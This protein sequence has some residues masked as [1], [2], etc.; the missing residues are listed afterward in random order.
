[1]A[2]SSV[3]SLDTLLHQIEAA[4]PVPWYPKLHAETTG[5]PRD[6]LDLPLEKLRMAGLIRLTEWMEGRGQGY[7]LTPEGMH[8][9][10]SERE[11]ARL[12][13]GI[14]P[15]RP[16]PERKST[17]GPRW[18]AWDRGE[19][20]RE[21]LLDPPN[22]VVAKSLVLI[23]IMVFLAGMYLA[24]QANVPANIYLF[25]SA[26]DQL[27]ARALGEAKHNI[28]AL[29]PE[30]LI[31]G[32]WWRLLTYCFVHHGLIHI[33]LNM[34]ALY[35]ISKYLEPMWGHVR[36]LVVYLIAGVGGGCVA[37][38]VKPNAFLAGASGA[39]CGLIAAEAVWIVL[40]RAHLPG[41]LF[42]AWMRNIGIN[43]ILI[44]IIST[45]PN[46]S[47]S[48][49]FGGAAIGAV[50]A[51]LLH[52]QRYGFGVARWLALVAVP[53]VPVAS[54]G[55]LI[56]TMNTKPLWVQFREK[57]Q[58]E[59]ARE[60]DRALIERY[61]R[62]AWEADQKARE[63]YNRSYELVAM[64]PERRD[65]EAKQSAIEALTRARSG[66]AEAINR[67]SACPPART[68]TLEEARLGT[69][70]YLQALADLCDLSLT[71]LR[72]DRNLL[73]ANLNA[74]EEQAAKVKDLQKR[75]ARY[76]Q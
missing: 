8:A 37:M 56:Y 30:D 32:Q 12:R 72:E 36:F 19:Q 9:L 13:D 64:H 31:R 76:I 40:N 65:P 68:A 73:G 67:V 22:A 21:V 34:A 71:D 61:R 45:L 70:E 53:L 11:L 54:V 33:L 15:P 46:V 48:A 1:M 49:H 10:K 52:Y 29:L 18:T 16:A 24:A 3:A 42:S 38:I 69:V 47:A 74:L 75:W 6:S 2:E 14:A 23:N 39:I 28:G 59:Q 66:L 57:V 35:G 26:R 55:A 5:V 27:Q 41:P 4:A 43:A 51:V 25:G 20:I 17:K 63:A 60:E 50:V 62:D 58:E 44:V 7:V